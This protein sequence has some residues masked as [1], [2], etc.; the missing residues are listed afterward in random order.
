LQNRAIMSASLTLDGGR[1]LRDLGPKV[2]ERI[3]HYKLLRQIGS[4]GMGEVYAAVDE[5][6]RRTVALKVLASEMASDPRRLQRFESEA[7]AAASLIHPNIAQVYEAGGDDGTRYIAMELIEGE[8]L[9]QRIAREELRIPDIV[10]LGEEL[11]E[12]VAEAHRQRIIHRDIKSTNVMLT[13]SG[14][15][16]VLDFGLA[17][18]EVPAEREDA[19]QWATLPGAVMGTPHSMSPEQALGQRSDERSDIFSIGVVLYEMVTRRM[20]FRGSTTAETLQKVINAEPEPMAR[21]NYELPIELEKIIRKCLEKQPERRY[22]SAGELLVDL[23]NL[24]RD[25]AKRTSLPLARLSGRSRTRK[26]RVV[27]GAALAIVLLAILVTWQWQGRRGGQ[28]TAIQKVAVFPFT[29][30]GVHDGEEQFAA[31]VTDEVIV[32]LSRFSGLRVMGRSTF[33]GLE[34]AAERLRQALKLKVDAHVTGT[35]R[36]D[37]RS[38]VTTTE[39]VRTSDGSLIDSD[40]KI[41]PLS[42]RSLIPRDIAQMVA[43]GLGVANVEQELAEYGTVNSEAYDLYLQGRRRWQ[44]RTEAGMKEA[45]DLFTRATDLDPDYAAA[46]AGLA[47]IYSLA[48]RYAGRPAAESGARAR[49]AARRAMNLDESLPEAHVAYA[50]YLETFEWN[51]REAEDSYR[52]AIELGP[53]YATAHHWNAML[54]TRLGRHREAIE[55]IEKARELDPRNPLLAAAAANVHYYA[56]NYQS[57][58]EEAA[59]ALRLDPSSVLAR[60]QL[61]LALAFSGEHARARDVLKRVVNETREVPAIQVQA[62]AAYAVSHAAAGD[63]AEARQIAEQL[64][65]VVLDDESSAHGNDDPKMDR[66]R[67]DDKS[68]RSSMF[69]YAIAVIYAMIGESDSAFLWLDRALEVSSFWLSLSGVEPAF[70]SIRSDPRFDLLLDNVGL[71]PREAFAGRGTRG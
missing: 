1:L 16:K 31:D 23:R 42:E 3:A 30:E 48:E 55:S 69:G 29:M 26:R 36:N 7:R 60:I 70:D 59:G 22:Q 39:L 32:A 47:D 6:L 61:G 34:D 21:F 35:I 65:K 71:P 8:T 54:L 38:L 15:V 28:L 13:S 25:L 63:M 40:R 37:G 50:S 46:Y 17:R 44:Q 5:H 67:D 68:P 66:E 62:L 19:T 52:R 41:R 14:H 33:F 9:E 20:P 57:S 49:Q 24:R 4:G 18:M 27:F 56:G 53:S 43:S 10:R 11:A 2:M 58:V 51:W 45:I 64:E 12:A